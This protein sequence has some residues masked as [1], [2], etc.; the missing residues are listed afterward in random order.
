MTAG[1][2][3]GLVAV[4]SLTYG[5]ALNNQAVAEDFISGQQHW[6]ALSTEFRPAFAAVICAI[7]A[8]AGSP[9][10]NP[11]PY[12]AVSF[13]INLGATLAVLLFSRRL[14]GSVGAATAL[15]LLFAL[16][17][18]HHE[19]VFWPA[20][21]THTWMSACLLLSLWCYLKWR[22]R[23]DWRWLLSSNVLLLLGLLFNP[24]AICGPAILLVYEV[25]WP[26]TRGRT[27]LRNHL[28]I[29]AR[30]LWPFLITLALFVGLVVAASGSAARLV[31]SQQDTTFYH[32]SLSFG[33][34]RDFAGYLSYALFPFVPLR[35]GGTLT[36]LGLS[37][38]A[39]IIV[40]AGLGKGNRLVRFGIAWI[41]ITVLPY[42]FFVPFGNADRY[43]YLPSV[44]F[45]MLVIGAFQMARDYVVARVGPGAQRPAVAL[46][47]TCVVLYS[48]LAIGTLQVRAQEWHTAGILAGQLLNQVFVRYPTIRPNTTLYFLG[49]PKQYGQA[50]VMGYGMAAAVTNHYASSPLEVCTGDDPQLLAAVEVFP[51]RLSAA[52]DDAVYVY[53]EGQLVNHSA[54][55]SDPAVRQLLAAYAIYR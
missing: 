50:S 26:D 46:G 49:L 30:R 55:L 18:R 45:C 51:P 27:S 17:P 43:F 13:S 21:S 36:K 33:Q 53:Q 44:G 22:A 14:T 15:T 47:L 25:L 7:D 1:A 42:V 39:G 40:A 52:S 8:V 38:V 28:Q 16:Y 20:A 29:L 10:A 4:L 32:L 9:S 34:A 12:H 31:G 24:A 48:A 37:L 35:T 41:G 11:A 5:S 6:E 2:V 19:A 54:S 3:F 23:A